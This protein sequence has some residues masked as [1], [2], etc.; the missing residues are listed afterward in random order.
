MIDLGGFCAKRL[1]F[2]YISA[3]AAFLLIREFF[4]RNSFSENGLKENGVPH[5]FTSHKHSEILHR[6]GDILDFVTQ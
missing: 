6:L 5:V 1:E 2:G 4:C 3:E